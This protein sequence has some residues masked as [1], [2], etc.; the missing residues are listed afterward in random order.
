VLER[1]LNTFQEKIQFTPGSAKGK[2][3]DAVGLKYT[4]ALPLYPKGLQDGYA[5]VVKLAKTVYGS[6]WTQQAVLSRA[7]QV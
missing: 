2:A 5:Y 4:T 3:L 6:P 1:F 7:I